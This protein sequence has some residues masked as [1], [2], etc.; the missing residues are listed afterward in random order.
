MSSKITIRGAR[1]HNLK[2]I[3]LELPRNQLIVFTGVSGSGKSS[4]A[5]DTIFAEGQ[6]RYVESLSAYARQFLGQ[7]DK[8]D[9][10]SIEGLSP[11]IS[12]DQKSTS[13]NPRSTVGTVTEIYD[14]LRLLYGRAGE[15]FCPHCDASIAPQTIDEMCDRILALPEKTKIYLL[16]P[17]VR[18]KKG[19]QSQLLSALRSQ[20]FARVK[21]NGQ[22]RELADNIE[23][24]PQK[25][26]DIS[27]VVDRLIVKP[28][29]QERLADSLATCLKIADGIAIVEVLEQPKDDTSEA[30]LESGDKKEMVFSEN[31]AC[32]THGAV[33]SELSPRLFSFNSPYGACPHCHGIGT[34]K[35]FS[36]D[37]IIPDP[38]VPVKYAIAPWAEKD[39]DYY[40]SLLQYT[41][42]EYGYNL[43]DSWDSL[44]EQQQYIV[45]YGDKEIQNLQYGY[46]RGVVPMLEKTYRETNSEIIKQKLEQY[47]EHQICEE[48]HGKRLKPEVLAVRL[49]QYKINDLTSVSIAD[50]LAK[51]NDIQLTPRQ[52]QIGELALREVK[53][54]LQFL[55]DVG[56]DYLTL[57]RTAMTL[58]GG[59]AQRIRLAT[60][61]GSGLTGVLYVL[62]E[63]SIGLHQR[64]N[65]RL[66]E[67]LK[68]LRDL[69]NTLI[70]VEHDEDTIKCAD[71]IVD[72]G[73]K[74]GVHGGEIVCQGSLDQLLQSKKSLTGAYLSGRK[75]IEVPD[76]RREGNGKYLTLRNCHRN[77][78]K[79]IDVEIP[80]GKFVCVTGVSGSGKSTLVN[81]LLYPALQHHLSRKVPFPKDLGSFEGIEE[82]DK[83]IVID[84]SPIGRTPRSNPATYTGVFDVIREMFTETVEAKARGYKA[85]RFSFNVKGGRCEACSGQGVNVISMN[86]LPDVYVQCDVCKG[87][88]YNRETLQV[89]YKGYSIADVL[90]MTIEEAL[91]VFENIPRAVNRLQTLV[92]VGLSYIKLGQSA[93]TLSGGEAQRVKLATELSRRATGKTIYLIDEPTTGLSF[94]DIHHLLNVL[95]RLANKGN[96]IVVIE[97]NLDVIKCADWI[98][99]L[100]LEGGDKGGNSVAMGTPEEIAK[101][102]KSY[103]AKYLK[104]LLKN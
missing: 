66:L 96:S 3:D 35:R 71:H 104:P 9:V 7:L 60:Q 42:E 93:P 70:I 10:D 20:G 12:I 82:I 61:I 6:R 50:C 79:H 86:F 16:A 23:L 76:T 30:S 72:I 68:K 64:D 51:I 63:P 89:K 59:E 91:E 8:P 67:T 75:K 34:L 43:R 69:D 29:I 78:L 41:A 28:K 24:Q 48:C 94:Y 21:V 85:G 95:Q 38:S 39:N 15:P 88:R 31:F 32:P 27:V 62:D 84:Q 53:E 45:L 14:Y 103:L 87:A 74:A 65:D 80:L 26:H 102:R 77:N 101:S 55:L 44:T 37:L 22:I 40:L 49:G 58:S 73:P 97:H 13:H 17:V 25:K 5:F 92:D 54:R 4:L 56:L 1:Q 100:G 19:N 90:D 46:Y 99:D 81:E 2:N 57:D 52:A 83:A 98:I 33:M 11:A 36:P 47:I 18:G